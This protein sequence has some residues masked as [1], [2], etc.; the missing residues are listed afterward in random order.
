MGGSFNGGC[1]GNDAGGEISSINGG[2]TLSSSLISSSGSSALIV[3]FSFTSRLSKSKKNIF[4]FMKS[5]EVL[6]FF[7]PKFHGFIP[8]LVK[9]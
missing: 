4:F 2:S 1:G 6:E 9:V 5:K 7:L 3:G 8:K